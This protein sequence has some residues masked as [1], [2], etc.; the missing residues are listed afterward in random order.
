MIVRAQDEQLDM[1]QD[2]MGTLRSVSSQIGQELDEQAMWV[3]W[4]STDIIGDY[5]HIL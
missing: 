3:D 4:K 5:N 2:S 1:I